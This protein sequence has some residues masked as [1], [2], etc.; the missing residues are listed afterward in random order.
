MYRRPVD[1]THSIG[2]LAALAAAMSI[3]ATSRRA[4]HANQPTPKRRGWGRKHE[5]MASR[6]IRGAFK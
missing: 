6:L 2:W 3:M 1:L 4:S 5:P